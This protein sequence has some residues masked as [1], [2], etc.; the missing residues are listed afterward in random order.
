MLGINSRVNEAGESCLKPLIVCIPLEIFLV[1]FCSSVTNK[2]AFLCLFLSIALVYLLNSFTRSY[3]LSPFNWK[4]SDVV[5][6]DALLNLESDISSDSDDSESWHSYLTADSLPQS[7]PLEEYGV[8]VDEDGVGGG[9]DQGAGNNPDPMGGLDD[10]AKACLQV[11]VF[12]R[13][14]VWNVDQEGVGGGE[15]QGK[16]NGPNHMGWSNDTA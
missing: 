10:K 15:D 7:L 5:L 2:L 14:S 8:D 4:H 12:P 9:E 11:G 3:F 16:G 6:N 13:R 1:R